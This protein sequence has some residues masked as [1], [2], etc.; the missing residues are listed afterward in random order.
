VR[1]LEKENPGPNGQPCGITLDR[2][3]A[4][5]SVQAPVTSLVLAG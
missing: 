4:P 5:A 2:F 3:N 1:W